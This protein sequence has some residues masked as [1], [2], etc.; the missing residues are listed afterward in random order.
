VDSPQVFVLFEQTESG[1]I[2]KALFNW[3]AN[4]PDFETSFPNSQIP[5]RVTLIYLIVRWIA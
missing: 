3:H 1:V 4:R 5:K 2:A